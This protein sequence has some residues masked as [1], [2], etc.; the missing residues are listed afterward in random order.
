MAV[1]N[2]TR[3]ELA[4]AFS[5]NI[6]T[7]EGVRCSSLVEHPFMV[8]WVIGRIPHGRPMTGITKAMVLLSSLRDSAYKRSIVPNQNKMC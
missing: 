6:N 3:V 5:V 4:D 7:T 2:T 1:I 8:R